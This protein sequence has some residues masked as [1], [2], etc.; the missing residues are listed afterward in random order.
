MMFMKKNYNFY[1]EMMFMSI[2]ELMKMQNLWKNSIYQ[3]MVFIG[4]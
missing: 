4:K 1:G 3:V 2:Y